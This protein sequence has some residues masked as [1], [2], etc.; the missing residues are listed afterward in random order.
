MIAGED[1]HSRRWAQAGEVLIKLRRQLKRVAQAPES[2][3]QGFP[4]LL[5]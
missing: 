2:L 3:R 5:C 1:A 4:G